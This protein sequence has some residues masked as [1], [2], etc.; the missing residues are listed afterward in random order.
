MF[1]DRTPVVQEIIAR[2]GIASNN[3]ALYIKENNYQSEEMTYRMG[4]NICQLS[5]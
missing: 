1:L 4:E 5:I 2:I 3:K